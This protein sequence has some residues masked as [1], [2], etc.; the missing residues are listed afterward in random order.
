MLRLSLLKNHLLGDT[1][2]M[3]LAAHYDRVN[4]SPGAN[5]NSAAVFQLVET[6][7]LLKKE[8]AKRW[9]I[10][11]TDKEELGTGEGVCDQGA[12][13]L[14]K[15]LRDAGFKTQDLFIFD[16]CGS[17]DT[18]IISTVVDILTKNDERLGSVRIRHRAQ[19]LR[20]RALETARKLAL[21]RVL[22][23]STPFSDDAGFLR[24]GIAA[25]T[26]TMLPAAEAASLVSLVR[27]KPDF[28]DALISRNMPENDDKTW[29][30]ATWRRLNG[31][32]DELSY[33]TP[34]HF[35]TV[36]RFAQALCYR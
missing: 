10:L 14:A 12:Y 2:T 20:T 8:Q 19:Q 30:P 13:T 21:D 16:A 3:V 18:L 29:I 34:Q 4:G 28:A 11:F 26:I 15:G 32:D 33:L 27:N 35:S 7:L 17:G 24:A 36:V 6:A 23:S 5:D 22:L 9:F 1:E 25:Q 31:S